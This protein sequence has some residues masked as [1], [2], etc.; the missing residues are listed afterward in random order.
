[1]S[2]P[3][4]PATLG[5]AATRGHSLTRTNRKP[6]QGNLTSWLSIPPPEQK[7]GEALGVYAYRVLRH[8]LRLGLLKPREHLRETE[9]ADWLQIS[10]TPVREAMHRIASEGLLVP[11]PWNGMVVAEFTTHQL[12]QLYAVREVLEGSAAQLAARHASPAEVDLMRTIARSEV[13]V[14]DD[15]NKLVQ[16]NAEL[17]NTICNAAHNPFLLQSLNV[18]VDALGLVRHSTFVLPGS[19]EQAH[20]DHLAIIE[21]ISG[22]DPEKA[23]TAARAHVRKSLSLRLQLQRQLAAE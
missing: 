23:E 10:R 6:S 21:A 22:G 1:M 20:R 18:I 15:P 19:V 11:G 17:H 12:V 9:V 8:G 5:A 3:Y 13:E 4:A 2:L 16:L 7:P 14:A